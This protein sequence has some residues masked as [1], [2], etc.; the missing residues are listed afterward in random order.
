MAF[1]IHSAWAAVLVWLAAN[2]GGPRKAGVRAERIVVSRVES[3]G[4]PYLATN[5]TLK[6]QWSHS[7]SLSISVAE[8]VSLQ[9]RPVCHENL[10]S[11]PRVT[12]S[13]RP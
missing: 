12:G 3:K 5:L 1:G 4:C 11:G 9:L 13:S 2:P 6:M 7:K 10:G 8:W